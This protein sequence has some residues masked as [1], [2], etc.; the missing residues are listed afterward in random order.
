MNPAFTQINLDDKKN[1]RDWFKEGID[2]YRQ[3]LQLQNYRSKNSLLKTTPVQKESQKNL[4]NQSINTFTQ[5]INQNQQY[6]F[7]DKNQITRKQKQLQQLVNNKEVQQKQD[8]L[9]SPQN[10]I[11]TLNKA[12]L[13]SNLLSPIPMKSDAQQKYLV[14]SAFQT[15]QDTLKVMKK[16]LVQR[17]DLTQLNQHQY[18]NQEIL[19][20]ET[21]NNLNGILQKYHKGCD[22]IAND[23][24][25]QSQFRLEKKDQLEALIKELVLNNES[26][27][28]L[29]SPNKK[30]NNQLQLSSKIEEKIRK[31]L[32]ISYAK[33]SVQIVPSQNQLNGKDHILGQ[34]APITIKLKRDGYL[35]QDILNEDEFEIPILGRFARTRGFESKTNSSQKFNSRTDVQ[36]LI[37]VHSQDQYT[38]NDDQQSIEKTKGISINTQT[39]LF[40]K[41]KNFLALDN[42]DLN[43]SSQQ[44]KYNPTKIAVLQVVDNQ[45]QETY[46]KH[47]INK[48]SPS[49]QQQSLK[50]YIG[51]GNN[52]QL[53]KVLFK[54]RILNNWVQVVKKKGLEEST[55]ENVNFIWTQVKRQHIMACFNVA[56]PLEESQL[57]TVQSVKC[58]GNFNTN[59]ISADQQQIQSIKTEAKNVITTAN[60]IKSA[61]IL[62]QEQLRIYGKLENNYHLANK[63]ALFMNMKN[64]YEALDQDPFNAIPLTFHIK[65]GINDPSF[66]QF[67]QIFEDFSQN[68]SLKNVWIIK[69]GENTNRGNG[70]QVS[71]KLNE[72]I[73]IVQSSNFDQCYS[74]YIIQKYI[75]KPLLIKKRKFDIRCYGLFTSVNG[76]QKGYFY[77][78]GYI[79][80]SCKEYNT[81]NLANKFIHLT[82]DAVQKKCD[83]YG[84][85]ENG[86]KKL[87]Q[88]T[89]RAVYTK[90]DPFKRLHG[91]EIFGYDFMI[92]EDFKIYLIEVNTNPC[93]ET[94]CPLLA[95]IIYEMV[96]NSLRIGFDPLFLNYQQQQT[97]Y[98]SQNVHS[99]LTSPDNKKTS[100][101]SKSSLLQTDLSIPIIKYELVFDEKLDGTF[102][103]NH[104]FSKYKNQEIIIIE[105]EDDENQGQDAIQIDELQFKE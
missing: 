84:K 45:I 41:H 3:K 87:I 59:N 27:Q 47:P 9:K 71:N 21:V 86:N 78:D 61:E 56:V 66:T 7:E 76:N 28:E 96:D 40:L 102:L 43:Y 30:T 19:D 94:S 53:V 98:S 93:L 75:E 91:F 79:R 103:K 34:K 11:N 5:F 70:I 88:D 67:K 92:D 46:S 74:T 52:G 49:Q 35:T 89:Y 26:Q 63:K 85:F 37:R 15:P 77:N 10:R 105:E 73:Q 55:L 65:D 72:I 38:I 104:V 50:Y 42:E 69:P 8:K 83:D 48:K 14:Q 16:E 44:T 12:P 54:Q 68:Q 13:K 82:N 32:Q 31:I 81:N 23:R 25:K 6:S 95:R 22:Q 4:T 80:T 24:I 33:I 36:E 97:S 100:Q 29:K 57:N 18:Q 101:K 90:I 1:V 64:Y 2:A 62:K 17:F 58:N 99:H 60:E 39:Q 20:T 51:K